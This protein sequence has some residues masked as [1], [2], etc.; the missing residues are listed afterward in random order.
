VVAD[1]SPSGNGEEADLAV[2]SCVDEEADLAGASS[3]DEL[4]SGQRRRASSSCGAGW[5][6]VRHRAAEPAEASRVVELRTRW[7]RRAP[8][9]C[10]PGRGAVCHR[11]ADPAG[12]R[13]PLRSGPDRGVVEEAPT[14]AARVSDGDEERERP[15][16]EWEN[17]WVGGISGISRPGPLLKHT[18]LA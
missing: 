17:E 13:A 1:L 3:I 5:G 10:G 15:R 6:V 12:R 8:S 7:G 9:R 2:A 4:R 18:H 11:G 16:G 14:V